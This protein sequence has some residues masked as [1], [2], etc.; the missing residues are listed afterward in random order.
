MLCVETANVAGAAISL[1][2]GARHAMGMTL[3]VAPL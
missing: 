3:S 1:A 2:P